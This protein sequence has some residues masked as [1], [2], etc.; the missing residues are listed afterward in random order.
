[1]RDESNA[2]AAS[3]DLRL[4]LFRGLANW[5]IFLDHI[6]HEIL[7]ALTIRNYGFSDAAD[8]FVFI[9]GYTIARV[10]GRVLRERGF[11]EGA[12]RLLKRTISL[13][14]VHVLLA[15]AYVVLINI[16]AH[17]LQ[18]L[19]DLDRF[20]V[21]LMAKDPAKLAVQ[22]LLLRYKPVNLDILPLYILLLIAAIPALWLMVRKPTLG[23]SG[24]LVLY[25][26]ARAFGWNL[27]GYP[28]GTWYFNPFAWQLLFFLGSWIALGGA[29]LLQPFIQSGTMFWIAVAYVFFSLAVTLAGQHPSYG[30]VLP[31]WIAGTFGHNDKTNLSPFRVVHLIAIVLIATRFISQ[32]SPILRW[33]LFSPMIVCG[34]HSLEVF[35]L[36]IVLSY[37]A[38]AAIEVESNSIGVQIIVGIAGLLILS[39]TALVFGR[40]PSRGGEG[41]GSDSS[42]P[43]RGHQRELVQNS[44]GR[45]GNP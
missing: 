2:H 18:D 45:S 25:L 16:I 11:V 3:R 38:H 32:H 15:G 12:A 9:S 40:A 44:S 1:M 43:W 22:T 42:V 30:V 26:A 41:R 20:N 31:D 8:V 27:S 14:A 28:S 29:R 33:R 19:E 23:L 6:P 35:C 17:Q 36:G 21:A 13:Y 5:A 10:F 4:D 24:S 34:Q 7:S 37:C 39:T